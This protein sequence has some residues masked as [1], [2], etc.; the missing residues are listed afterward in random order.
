MSSTSTGTEAAVTAAQVTAPAVAKPRDVKAPETSAAPEAA[1]PGVGNSQ[2]SE[3]ITSVAEQ[4]QQGKVNTLE[5]I[6]GVVDDIREAIDTLNDALA[7]S[8][9][10]AIISRDD[11]L[12]RFIVKIADERSGEVIREIPSEAVLKFARNLREIK[13]L[14]FDKLL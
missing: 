14:L 12:N 8:P 9:T 10:K 1:N 6:S 11:Q 7:K 5:S 2:L 13:G 4:A 3:S